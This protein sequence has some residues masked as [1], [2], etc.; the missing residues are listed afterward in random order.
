MLT[1]RNLY[2]QLDFV[3]ADG[4]PETPVLIRNDSHS[5]LPPFYTAVQPCSSVSAA[6][7][8]VLEYKHNKSG[9]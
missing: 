4:P 5:P 6:I 1:L 3:A 2:Y 8:P 7:Q 9:V